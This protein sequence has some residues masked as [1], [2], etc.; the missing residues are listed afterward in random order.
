[1]ALLLLVLHAILFHQTTNAFTVNYERGPLIASERASISY[2][3]TEKF[4]ALGLS[5]QLPRTRNAVWVGIG[6]TSAGSLGMRGADLFS[7]HFP[8]NSKKCKKT[9]DRHAPFLAYPRNN[10]SE[11]IA[12]KDTVKDKTWSLKSCL[13]YS[14]GTIRLEVKRL[15]IEKLSVEDAFIAPGQIAHVLH[16]YG[17][18]HFKY[19][20]MDNRVSTPVMIRPT[21]ISDVTPPLLTP[22]PIP[23]DKNGQ[24]TFSSGAYEVTGS[25]LTCFTTT[26]NVTTSG[27]MVIAM[28]PVVKSK[29]VVRMIIYGC[30]DMPFFRDTASVMNQCSKAQYTSATKKEAR[31]TTMFYSWAPG[32]GELV[33]PPE[34]GI[35]LN[36]GNRRLIMEVTFDNV[37]G[38]YKQGDAGVDFFYTNTP[39]KNEIGSMA[40]GAATYSWAG[41]RVQNVSS[42]CPQKCTKFWQKPINLFAMHM[43]MGRYGQFIRVQHVDKKKPKDNATSTMARVYFWAP[44]LEQLHIFDQPKVIKPGDEMI[45]ACDTLPDPARDTIYGRNSQFEQ[46]EVYAHY[47]PAQYRNN[48][49]DGSFY[50]CSS[51][52]DENGASATLC[53]AGWRANSIISNHGPDCFPGNA[54]VRLRD[55]T[56]VTMSNLKV[57]DQVQVS[58]GVYSSVY[59]FSHQRGDA[60]HPFVVLE[61]NE[62]NVKFAA[63]HGHLLYVNGML[64]RADLVRPGDFVENAHGNILR[65]I[66]VSLENRVGLYNP[67][68]M[69]GDIIVDGVRASTFTNSVDSTV[70]HALLAPLRSVF[71]LT[72][73]DAATSFVCGAGRQSLLTIRNLVLGTGLN[74]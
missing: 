23:E 74:H 8:R 31:C 40:M 44:H 9:H 61:F 68:T 72:S 16:A 56:S 43:H 30:H 46:C 27:A 64:S 10:N 29:S 12:R 53:G 60:V 34:A 51:E 49:E 70:A 42:D 11:F 65:V 26:V 19:H 5:V 59:M 13:R 4:V 18:G 17:E 73:I 36:S 71:Y 45:V 3:T 25:N 62:S 47:W 38:S 2:T 54:M 7:A 69:H 50:Y 39:R 52:V 28:K 37:L 41:I 1:M 58:A 32:I 15:F 63:T 33:F 6:V 67:Q 66:S 57:G 48:E 20:K 35:T 22:T 14:N 55:G 21:N 24:F